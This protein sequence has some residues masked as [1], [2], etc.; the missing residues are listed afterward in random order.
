METAWL[1]VRKK[2]CFNSNW[3]ILRTKIVAVTVVNINIEITGAHQ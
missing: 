2:S 1:R 3:R